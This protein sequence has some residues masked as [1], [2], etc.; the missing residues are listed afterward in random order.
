MSAFDPKRTSAGGGTLQYQNGFHV[1]LSV[2]L[3]QPR[4][5]PS[6]RPIPERIGTTTILFP[7]SAVMPKP[8]TRYRSVDAAEATE[9]R[10][11][12]RQAVNKHHRPCTVSSEV[13]PEARSF[14]EHAH[15]TGISRIKR[16]V[17]IAQAADKSA[18]RFFT[19]NI[20]VGEA[21]LAHRFLDY[22]SKVA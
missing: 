21:P 6:R 13:K 20:A 22:P 16:A 19:K 12:L 14:P 5:A 1:G 4:L 9:N 10:S 2:N 15:V 3:S 7:V 18:A 11:G 8:P 17:A